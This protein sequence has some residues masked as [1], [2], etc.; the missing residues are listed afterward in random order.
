MYSSILKKM[1]LF[2][3]FIIFI[4]SLLVYFIDPLQYYKKATWYKVRYSEP[5]AMAPGML[6][7]YTYDSILIGSSMAQNFLISDLNKYLNGEFIKITKGGINSY[8]IDKILKYINNIDSKKN[9]QILLNI[10]YFS[11]T[12][13]Y[14]NIQIE[15]PN[16]LYSHN[17]FDKFQYLYSFDSWIRIIYSLKGNLLNHF[18]EFDFNSCFSWGHQFDY[19]EK[20]VLGSLKKQKFDNS[21]DKNTHNF[22]VM[23]RNFEMHILPHIKQSTE[24]IIFLPPYSILTFNDIDKKGW[25]KDILEF[26]NYLA[27]LLDIY[28]NIRVYDFQ[29]DFEIMLNLNNYKDISHYSPEISEKILKDMSTNLFQIKNFEQ[30][31]KNNELLI[32]AINRNKY[33]YIFNEK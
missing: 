11:F 5:I 20:I 23:R 32:E 7:N 27:S 14:Q 4:I 24:Y 15:F 9:N 2:T 12:K 22:E 16:Y 8:E 30:M 21:F 28:P 26:R 31:M 29:I 19:S 1:F 25:L 33:R 18:H 13:N 10:D 17:I 6:R 3:S